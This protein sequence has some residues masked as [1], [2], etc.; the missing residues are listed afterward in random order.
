MLASLHHITAR[1]PLPDRQLTA[2]LAGV[3]LALA[4]AA[5]VW[6]RLGERRPEAGGA[7]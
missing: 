4:L 2:A 1:F 7:R 5:A 6:V 3:A